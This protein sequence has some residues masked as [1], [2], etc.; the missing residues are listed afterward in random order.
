MWKKQPIVF[1]HGSEER[2]SNLDP[3]RFLFSHSRVTMATTEKGLA[4]AAGS[5]EATSTATFAHSQEVR[6]SDS[7]ISS[8]DEEKGQAST[9]QLPRS[10]ENPPQE[11]SVFEKVTQHMNEMMMKLMQ[12]QAKMT[13]RLFKEMRDTSSE[14]SRES[15][16]GDKHQRRQHENRLEPKSFQRMNQFA[17][18]EGLYRE[19]SFDILITAE[20]VCPGITAMVEQYMKNREDGWYCHYSEFEMEHAEIR[21]K[22]FYNILCVLTA[23]EAKLS[24]RDCADGLEAWHKLWSTYN[25]KT[26]ARSLRMYKEAISPKSATHAGEV[27]I[28]ITEW[29]AKVKDLNKEEGVTL[30]PM[31]MLATLTEICTP[32]I[33]DMIYQQGDGLFKDKHP[34][35]MK[36]AFDDIREKIISWTSNKIASSSAN[37]NVGNFQVDYPYE[38]MYWDGSEQCQPCGYETEWQGA[39]VDVLGREEG[40]LDPEV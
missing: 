4:M 14:K 5:H 29:E 1:L 18:G 38:E 37:L 12:E 34:T 36:R 35:A 16:G 31:I 32:E 24:I 40:P 10:T 15:G 25:R 13:E 20:A 11:I 30:D 28:R 2:W 22:E 9:E 21:A 17:G 26:L 27:I 3:T 8:V 7:D 33:K 39:E 23:G 6:M 19:W